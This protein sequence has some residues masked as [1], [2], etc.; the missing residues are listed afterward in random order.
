MR[1]LETLLQDSIQENQDQHT[2]V[3]FKFQ[4]M[5][6]TNEYL[7]EEMESI[8]TTLPHLSTTIHSQ[9]QQLQRTIDDN[10]DF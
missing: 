5:E 1:Q 2:N 4:Q 6:N 10:T 7:Q 3:S 8:M 9:N